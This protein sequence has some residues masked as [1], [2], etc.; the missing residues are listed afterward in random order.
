MGR[1]DGGPSHEFRFVFPCEGT[2]KDWLVVDERGSREGGPAE[3]DKGVEGD[4]GWL[5]FFLKNLPNIFFGPLV[6][7]ELI[8]ER[9]I[10][11]GADGD[12]STPAEESERAD[13]LGVW[14][15]SGP[16]YRDGNSS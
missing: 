6:G 4:D 9:V 16:P 10:A 5:S 14:A 13:E 3:G 11:V 1:S 12:A 8:S 15:P 2:D 7:V